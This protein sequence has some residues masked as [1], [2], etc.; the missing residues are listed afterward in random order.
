MDSKI[1]PSVSIHPSAVIEGEVEIG[2]G[3]TIGPLC[4]IRG[5]VK[6]GRDN[7]I[8]SHV[9]IGEEP[10]HL[11][12]PGQGYIRIGDRNIIREL[13]VIQRG[14]GEAETSIANDCYIMDHSHIAHD[15]VLGDSVKISPNVVLGGHTKVM[16][17]ATLGISSITHQ[18]SIVGAYAMIGMGCVVTKDVFPFALVVGNP[19][20]Y[21]RW[22]THVFAKL[23]LNEHDFKKEAGRFT[24]THA[25][26]KNYFEQFY[27]IQ[28]RTVLSS[29][30]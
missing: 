6:I 16:E 28:K 2:P 13:T 9:I 17:A 20:R 7:R 18:W 24:S 5:P 1:H 4:Y 23:G 26:A 27:R 11:A 25:Q 30:L 14:T 21:S 22:N 29:E 19:V 10:E 3:T 12:K 8:S 15:C